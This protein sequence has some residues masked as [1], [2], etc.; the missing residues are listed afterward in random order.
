MESFLRVGVFLL[1]LCFTLVPLLVN[2]SF[3]SVFLSVT[4]AD[5]SHECRFWAMVADSFSEN[6]V[7]DHLINDPFS[8]KNLGALNVD[9]WGLA[10]YNFSQVIVRRGEPSAYADPNFDSAALELATSGAQIGVGH[11]RAASSGASGIPDPHPFIRQKDGKWWAFGHNGGLNK[12][13]LRNLIGQDYLAQNPPTVGDNWTDPDVIDSDLYMLY[14]LKSTEESNWN[15]TLGVAKAVT[16]L[17]AVDSGAM[18]FFLTDGETLWGFRRGLT[19]YYYYNATNPQYSAIASQPPTSNQDGWVALSD[20]NLIT[21]TAGKPPVV[22]EDIKTVPE[23]PQATIIT[24]FLLTTLLAALA[25][26]KSAHATG[27]NK[28]ALENH[29]FYIHICSIFGS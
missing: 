8:L 7:L 2:S 9:G 1:V 20:Y 4:E 29:G 25:Y 5:A 11:V 23:F 10:Y 3:S 16:D 13:T 26:R 17:S 18:N 12:D 24:F 19:L 28:H 6:V 22:I 15:V 27:K 21:L 14:L